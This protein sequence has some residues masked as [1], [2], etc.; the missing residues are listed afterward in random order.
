MYKTVAELFRKITGHGP[1][2]EA[3]LSEKEAKQLLAYVHTQL[4]WS[5]EKKVI[6][7]GTILFRGVVEVH[8]KIESKIYHF[9]YRTFS[10]K[11]FAV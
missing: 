1:A 2:W 8:V 9:F 10:R 4:K 6:V 11:K 3:V 5:I 7:R